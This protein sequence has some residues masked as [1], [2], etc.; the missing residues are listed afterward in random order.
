[1][2]AMS[3][4]RDGPKPQA[5]VLVADLDDSFLSGFLVGA[6]TQEEA[7]GFVRAEKVS[8]E[9]GR[10]RMDDGEATALLV[11]PNRVSR[12][13]LLLEEPSVLELITNPVAANPAGNCGRVAVHVRGRHVLPASTHRR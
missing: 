3:G 13:H 6:L 5:H 12:T 11:I 7:G 2:T 9:E 4:G 1:M 8:E 10:A